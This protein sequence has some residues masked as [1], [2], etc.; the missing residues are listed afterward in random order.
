MTIKTLKNNYDKE[1]QEVV[2]AWQSGAY[3]HIN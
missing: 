2:I 1:K 3:I